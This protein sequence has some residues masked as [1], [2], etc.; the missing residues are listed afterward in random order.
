[1]VTNQ[2]DSGHGT[3]MASPIVGETVGVARNAHLHN[4]KNHDVNGIGDPKDIVGG[5]NNIEVYREN[6]MDAQN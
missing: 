1:M 3:A 4:V 2:D 6:T 5:F